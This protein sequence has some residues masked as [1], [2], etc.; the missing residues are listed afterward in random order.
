MRLGTGIAYAITGGAA[1][2]DV[3]AV[4]AAQVVG[5]INYA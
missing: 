5:T 1:V 3:T 4:A 2:A